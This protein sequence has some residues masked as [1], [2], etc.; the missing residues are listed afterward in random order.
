MLETKRYSLKEYIS[1]YKSDGTKGLYK[2]MLEDFFKII[3]P[4]NG[5][6]EKLSLSYVD[7]IHDYKGDLIK[8]RDAHP[9]DSPMTMQVR[10]SAVNGFLAYNDILIS[11][12][13]RK[14]L[15]GKPEPISDEHIPT[16]EELRRICEYLPFNAKVFTIFLV[17]SGCRIGEALQLKVSDLRLGENPPK[18]RL[19]SD[20]TK[21]QRKRWT[22]LTREAKNLLEEWLR[23]RLEY[24]RKSN[25]MVKGIAAPKVDD[26]RVFPFTDD[27]Y[28]MQWRA[29][30]K[31]AGL[32]E[33][34]AKTGHMT[35][36]VHT[37][38]KY[39]RV[40][41]GWVNP[42]F[43]EM[44]M[45]HIG[46]VRGVYARYDEGQLA[47]AYLKAEL[48]LSVYEESGP[49]LELRE[50]VER[51]KGVLV[52]REAVIARKNSDLD[53]LNR[54]AIVK[55]ARLENEMELLK[56]SGEQMQVFLMGEMQRMFDEK[57]SGLFPS[58]LDLH[59]HDPGDE[60]DLVYDPAKV[61]VLPQH[62]SHLESKIS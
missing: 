26:G 44:L 7:G 62:L 55:I 31:K 33:V 36:H 41:G 40:R 34:D 56:R 21:T 12:K 6:I 57:M 24:L 8:L 14:D 27:L 13:F 23:F 3:Y 16:R 53:E 61:I 35:A 4:G 50:E 2:K 28:Y 29:A 38:R 1:H 5:D 49:Y 52:E 25:E 59:D 32:F 18:I 54:N 20:T 45:G 37:L 43:A 10:Y 60:R 15:I 58:E 39:F 42:E 47:E 17:A 30:V 11:S 9:K 51:Q 22:Y 48:N 46:G 19:R